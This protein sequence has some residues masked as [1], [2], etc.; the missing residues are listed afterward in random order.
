MFSVH[1]CVDERSPL[2]E[3]CGYDIQGLEAE[4]V[5]PECSRP[6]AQSLPQARPG[7]LWQQRPGLNSWWRTN[8]EA[9][10]H[11]RRLFG[12]VRVEPRGSTLLAIINCCIAG[13]LLIDPWVGA[14]VGDP[15]RAARTDGFTYYALTY[16]GT[17]AAETAA[18]AAILMLLTWVEYQG[19]RFIAARRKWRLTRAAAW[20]VCCHASVG[21]IIA[22]FAPLLALA[23]LHILRSILHIPMGGTIDMRAW[24]FG[25]LYIGTLITPLMLF[26]FMTGGMLIY[27]LLVHLGVR[28]CRFA[29]TL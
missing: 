15:V 7:S 14:L 13:F 12:A 5:C 25:F 28:C 6:I 22:A 21:W 9:L 27:E 1:H 11:P 8:L 24:G 17:L 2:C 26:V 19:V 18:V 29:A 23:L 4:G 3:K 20:Q 16:I 10:M